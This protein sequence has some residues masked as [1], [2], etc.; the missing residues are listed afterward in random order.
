MIKVIKVYKDS[1]ILENGTLS[2]LGLGVRTDNEVDILRFK[3]D[4]LP[5]GVGTLL[6]TL[7]DNNDELVSFPL[8]RNEEEN[9][10]DL[11]ITQALVSQLS[12][13]FQ[14][15]IVNGT[16][17]WNSLQATL[18]VHE[19]LEV[20]QGEM[21]TSIDN[22][23]INANIILS[24]IENTETTRNTNENSRITNE[25]L[26]VEAEDEREAYITDLKQRVDNGEFNGKDGQDGAT[27]PVGPKG[28]KGDKGDT[29]LK[30]DKG[31]TGERG[32]QGEKGSK[33]DTGA[34]GLDAKINGVN[35]LT[36]EE[37]ENITIT[38]EGSTMT[39][40]STGSGG[41]S[42]YDDL[43]NKPSINNVTLSG[44]KSLSDLGIQPSGNY[45]TNTDYANAS[46]GG[47][48]KT[49][50]A[51]YGV[52]MDSGFLCGNTRTYEQYSS[53]PNSLIISKGTLENIITGKELVSSSDLS[54]VAT[55]GSYNDLSDKP[56]IPPTMSI[57]SYGISTWNDFISAYNSNSVVYCRASSNSNPATGSQTR[58][59]FMAY[60]NNATN[61][62]EVEFQ[63]Y[64]SVSSH[65]ASQQGDQVF[66]YKL[67]SGGTWSVTTREAS[68]KVVAGTNMTSSYS[69]DTLTLSVNLSG[70]ATESYVD[71]AIESAITD[72]LGGS[73]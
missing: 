22:W 23:L 26:R 35:T 7:K 43:T 59:G 25:R 34:N 3:F 18:K 1:R 46:T 33:G 16:E 14:I 5:N 48:I 42:D 37:G 64:R 58:L 67:T 72:A 32:P 49:A 31:D 73:Y 17:I 28:D 56:T 21:P 65:T 6:T 60:V 2:T 20:G 61:P 45:V 4:V 57:L 52:T 15:Q 19:C 36:I 13:T 71:N 66:V 11:V 12:I 63:Y 38:Q 54:S 70:Y 44:N 53:N 30:G 8:T 9:S 69:N 62:T 24:G 40:S 39:I 29:G 47:V 10:L 68:S 51:N 41:T 50:P 27:G 55:S